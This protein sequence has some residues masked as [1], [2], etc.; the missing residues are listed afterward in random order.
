MKEEKKREEKI[1]TKKTK[2]KGKTTASVKVS[3]D[4][5]QDQMDDITYGGYDDDFM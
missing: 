5:W 4:T 2:K 1:S 3:G